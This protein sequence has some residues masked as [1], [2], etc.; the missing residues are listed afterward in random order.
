MSRKEIL[1]K[2]RDEYYIKKVASEVD[3]KYLGTFDET[4]IYQQVPVQ[5]GGFLKGKTETRAI[6]VRMKK[7]EMKKAIDELS[8]RIS[9]I[10]GML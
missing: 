8:N 6:T 1:S 5:G 4:E 7:E 3:L 10:D 2:I 9:V